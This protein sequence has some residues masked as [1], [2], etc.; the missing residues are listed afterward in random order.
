MKHG[1]GNGDGNGSANGNEPCGAALVCGGGIAGIQAALDLSAA[2]F[3]VHLV[4]ES[5][6][7]G[8]S[9]AR[10]DK[11]FPTGDCATCIISP[12]LVECMRD[13]NIDV[14]TM[15]DVLTLDG[16]AGRFRVGIRKRPRGVRADKCTGCGDCWT[17]C[18][19]RCTA[20]SP[21]PFQPSVPLNET[22]AAVLR[23]IL[24]RHE[25]DP[26]AMM[27]VLQEVNQAY[28]YIPRRDAGAP[29]LP[30]ADAAGGDLAGGQ[31]LRPISPGAGGPPH[32]RSLCRY[33]VPCPR[34]EGPARAVGTTARRR[35]RRNRPGR[36]LH[37]A[38]GPLPGAVRLSP[39][40]KIDGRS[41]GR[42]DLGR[43]PGILEQFA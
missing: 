11:T 30:V 39:A 13:Y 20:E 34:I 41:F 15:T 26:G 27:P 5:P 22:D 19:V 16:E 32:R 28:G 4:E 38:D 3:R 1:N 17:V 31:L 43:V 33:V 37:A 8:G 2:G 21:P 42:V 25:G 36:A 12:K 29:G 40:M 9:M 35:G 14:L 6:T 23:D 18:P 24:A 10:L 7:I